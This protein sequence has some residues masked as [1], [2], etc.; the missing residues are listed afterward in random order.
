MSREFAR[1]LPADLRR[2]TRQWPWTGML[3][4]VAWSTWGERL[5]ALVVSPWFSPGATA[6]TIAVVLLGAWIGGWS[7]VEGRL[8][9]RYGAARLEA[10]EAVFEQA[11]DGVVWRVRRV[12][13]TGWQ[14]TPHGVIVH[15]DRRVRA[16][17]GREFVGAR[18]FPW[19]QPLLVPTR[20][21]AEVEDVVAWLTGRDATPG[22]DAA[23]AGP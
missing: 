15:T 19:F 6:L 14:V 13:V 12:D 16:R 11:G 1:P 2:L 18:L 5:A 7:L 20:D 3:V 9:R 21:A 17:D 22:R 4:F 23:V 8:R 10:E